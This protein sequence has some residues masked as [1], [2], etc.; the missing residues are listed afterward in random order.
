[1][2]TP[3]AAPELAPTA[4]PDGLSRRELLAATAASAAAAALPALGAAGCAAEGGA[5]AAR[6]AAGPRQP[7]IY[8][9]HGGGPWPFVEMGLPRAELDLLRAYLQGLPAR[10][11]APPRAL[12][13]ISAHWEEAVATVQTAAAPP[14]LFDYSGFPPASYQLTWPAPGDPALAARVRALLAAAGIPSGEDGARGFDHGT[15]VPLK[16][17]WPGAAVPTVQLS[18]VQGLDPAAHLA[19]GRALAPLRDEGVLILG[20]GMSTH[21]L[22]GFGDPRMIPATERFDA[23]VGATCA[24]PP[25]AREAALVAWRSAPDAR[26]NHPREEH[27]LPLMVVAGAA[28]ADPGGVDWRG[29]FAGWRLSAARFG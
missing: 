19:L 8:L 29:S 15:F 10:L 22:R 3:P 12:L 13:V 7:V 11:P 24:A 17:A 28:G 16:V 1:M 14:L 25:P 27:L 6:A 4:G 5:P 26:L 18:L 23:W 9:P 20:S 2:S 21:N